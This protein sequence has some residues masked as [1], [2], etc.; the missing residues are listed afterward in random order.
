MKHESYLILSGKR[1]QQ[2]LARI[3]LVAVILLFQLNAMAQQRTISGTVIGADNTPLPGVS[4]MVKGT[5]TGT[6]TDIEGKYT[7]PIPA[8]S[9]T[10]VFSFIGMETKEVPVTASNVYDVTLAESM[11]GLEEVI[12]IGYGTAKKADLT[13]SV[14]RV[15]PETFQNSSIKQITEMLTGTVAGFSA[16]QG[17]KAAGGGDM[18]IRGPTS[19]SAGT[20]PLI[21]LDGVIYNGS[22]SDINPSDIASIDILKD[23]SSAAVFGSKA[24]NGVLL[25]TT[26]KGV[27]GKPVINFSAKVGISDLINKDYGPF[28]GDDYLTFRRDFFRTRNQPQPD[29]YW[30][31]PENLPEGVTLEQWRAAAGTP[32]ADNMQEWYSRM[33]LFP[34]EKE[35]AA[36]GPDH[37]LDWTDLVF[38]TGL[39][40][41]Y[42]LSMS[43]GTKDVRYYW[44]LGYLDN[45]GII[46]G[47]KFSAVR[48]RLNLDGDITPWMKVGINSQFTLR[49]QSTVEADLNNYFEMPAYSKLRNDD[50]TI[51]W[52]PNDYTII[53]N[54]LLDYY[55]QQRLYK[56][57]SLFASIWSEIKLPLG[58]SYRIAFQPRFSNS[59]DY[60]FWD[61]N[62]TTGAETHSGGYGEREDGSSYEWMIDNILKWNKTFGIHNFDVTFLQS[63]EQLL[64]YETTSQTAT[65]LPT[66]SLGWHG[67]AFGTLP[68]ALSNDTK[69]SGTALMARINYTL[70]D[71]Y[72][73]TASV[74]Q[75]GFSAFGQENPT[76]TFP[77]LAFAWK[78]SDEN[79]FSGAENV[80]NR[81]KLR[82]SWGVNGNRDIGTYSALSQLASNPYYNGSTTLIG[83]FANTLANTSLR[84]ERTNATNVGL[85]IGLL[86]D[87]I[88]IT[89]DAYN[90]ITTDLL[91]TRQLPRITGF[92]SIMANLGKLENRGIELTINTNNYTTERFN[93]RS[94]FVFSLNRSKILEL[95]GD[96]QTYTLLNQEFT[97]D[98]PDFTNE[99]FVGQ[100]IDVVWD[101]DIT[102]VWQNE[103]AAA[104]SE[105]LQ[106]PGW[107]KAD[108]VDGDKR[109]T[110]EHDKKFIGHETPRY[111]LGF[112]NDFTL[113]KNLTASFFFR[114][115]LGHIGS[116]PNVIIGTST[117]DRHNAL[118]RPYWTPTDP[119]NEWPSLAHVYD[120][121]GGGIDFYKPKGFV[122]LQD[123][124]L[125]YNIPT[126]VVNKMKVGSARVFV[127]AR[128]LATFTKWPG[129]DPETGGTNE[130]NQPMPR[131]FTLGLNLSL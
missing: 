5:T 128:N 4:V 113:F 117:Y 84:W 78:V 110:E 28:K 27:I 127:S 108:D 60:N 46:V 92:T 33:N 75:D 49:D 118:A 31:S 29:Y 122:R 42:D 95:F 24:A 48:S 19:L 30:F 10:L 47:D 50:G 53:D 64:T 69:R 103:E 6:L 54:P 26:Q 11:V 100:G 81:L 98:A 83:T 40:Q 58:F 91:M 39:N 96:I 72:L 85:D 52:Y 70:N 41:D 18:E 68:A 104:A 22:L 74:R 130:Q 71:K 116:R 21:V 86:K 66:E 43:G 23:A 14:V 87:R 119:N 51:K 89:I 12:V 55:G 59:K 57:N 16:N 17:N 126:A 20:D 80:M 76:A 93:W 97:G 34:V 3:F 79:F 9:N 1:Y 107:L 101:Y 67:M 105:F 94:N 121:F 73:L 123:A 90:S 125:A 44:S 13:G 38:Q 131:S 102:G 111:R 56:T 120:A 61:S 124:S 112:R 114:A 115:D 106:Q 109:Y 7:L 25:I 63:A 65:F 82:L 45:E 35:I 2:L 8:S 37:Y 129:W 36:L 15:Q 99:W 62:T 32:Q 77:A 88:D